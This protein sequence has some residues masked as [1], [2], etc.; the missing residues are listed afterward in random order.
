MSSEISSDISID[1]SSESSADISAEFSI[2]LFLKIPLKY[3]PKFWWFDLLVLLRRLV[4][5]SVVLI[6]DS[7]HDMN[8]FALF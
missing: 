1:I 6:F 7:E 5:T 2:D 3:R 8:S 4:L